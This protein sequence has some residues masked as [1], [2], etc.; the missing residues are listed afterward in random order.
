MAE[1]DNCSPQQPPRCHSALRPKPETMGKHRVRQCRK[2]HTEPVHL[3]YL[4]GEAA[5]LFSIATWE[6]VHM[7]AAI[8][9][10]CFSDIT[11]IDLTDG[12]GF[13][14]NLEKMI[15]SYGEVWCNL[16]ACTAS[17]HGID[18]FTVDQTDLLKT[19]ALLDTL[20]HHYCPP[21]SRLRW[22]LNEEHNVIDIGLKGATGIQNYMAFGWTEPIRE[23]DHMLRVD[24][25]VT[26]FNEEK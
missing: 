10:Q 4:N 21:V 20:R 6:N 15:K 11:E 3:Q 5:Y 14:R 23:H 18:K 7:C 16:R 22:T 25:A 9:G 1:R 17:N 12:K 13:L 19:N 2:L 8:A 26:G 24:V